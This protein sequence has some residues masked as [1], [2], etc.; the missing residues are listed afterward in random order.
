M[1]YQL[2]HSLLGEIT[3]HDIRFVHFMQANIC[4]KDS[5]DW[6]YD[7]GIT[8]RRDL[9]EG[10]TELLPPVEKCLRLV[11]EGSQ[12]PDSWP[13]QAVQSIMDQSDYSWQELL[14]CPKHLEW[15]VTEWHRRKKSIEAR[16]ASGRQT[17]R[18]SNFNETELVNP[19][20]A[21]AREVKGELTEQLLAAQREVERVDRELEAMEGGG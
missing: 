14:A 7:Q 15:E 17:P 9:A 21:E 4:D 11:V 6:R 16:R 2:R 20:N 3:I 19:M 12:L 5:S 8:I 10:S 13:H 18:G 1:I